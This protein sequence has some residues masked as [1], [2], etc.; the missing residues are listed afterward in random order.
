MSRSIDYKFESVVGNDEQIKNL[1]ELLKKRIY[2]ISHRALPDYKSHV[3]FV[4]NHPY[5]HWFIVMHKG[6]SYG[7]FYIKKDNSI[8]IN[9]KIV[10]NK[11]LVAVINFIKENFKPQAA[12]PS[13][14]P[15]YFYINVASSNKK[16]IDMLT[17]LNILPLQISLKI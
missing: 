11:I 6:D 14:V 17:A 9:F 4:K 10:D 7:S 13:S 1:Y 12:Q 5:L 16:L 3:N 15:E 2:S 8:G